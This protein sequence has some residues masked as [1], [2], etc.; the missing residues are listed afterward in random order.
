[1]FKGVAPK[2]I[3]S[4]RSEGDEG[5]AKPAERILALEEC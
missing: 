3:E 5:A 4:L 1:M 2:G